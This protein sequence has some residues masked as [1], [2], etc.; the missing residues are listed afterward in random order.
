M[1]E[2]FRDG[3]ESGV[4]SANPNAQVLVKYTGSFDDVAAGK[5]YAS[6]LF[7]QGADIVYTAAGKCG[8]GA[9]DEVRS[10]PAGDYIIGVDSDQDALAPGKVLTS[11][12]KHVDNAVFALAADAAKGTVPAGRV[13][14]GLKDGGVG[15][16]AM[17]YTR[18]LLPPGATTT[19]GRY[20]K[21]IIAGSI[22][23]PSTPAELQHF[24]PVAPSA[25]K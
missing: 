7:D 25:L 20:R 18:S 23:V 19:I 16:T 17:V 11:A 15:L 14:L 10:R 22:V 8:I 13:V 6:L 2:K 21:A 12:L 5:E 1:I 3:F 24:H 4:K 9:I